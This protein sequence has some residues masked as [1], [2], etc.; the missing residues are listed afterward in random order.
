MVSI[1]L[2]NKDT[3]EKIKVSIEHAC[4]KPSPWDNGYGTEKHNKVSVVNLKTRKRMSFDFWGSVV[5][6][7]QE[8]ANGAIGAI[9]CYA[10]DALSYDNARSFED[11]CSEFG[12]DTDSRN[13]EKIYKAC[14]K[15]HE[16]MSRVVGDN[17]T[18]LIDYENDGFKELK[19]K[20]LAE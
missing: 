3:D 16:K 8:S 14:G 2:I 4:E 10:S 18:F 17:Y 19:A 6:P 1:K 15:A 5:E 11:F 7:N 12:Y 20:G 13:A 9:A